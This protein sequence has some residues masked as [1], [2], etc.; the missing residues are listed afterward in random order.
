MKIAGRVIG[1]TNKFASREGAVKQQAEERGAFREVF[2]KGTYP[3]EAM[4]NRR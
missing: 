4:M 1:G 3:I 2:H